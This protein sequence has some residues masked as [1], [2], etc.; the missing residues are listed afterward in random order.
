MQ[1][2]VVPEPGEDVVARGA[3]LGMM[4]GRVRLH[5]G[6]TTSSPI[7]CPPLL[8]R[9]IDPGSGVARTMGQAPDEGETTGSVQGG[10]LV[11]GLTLQALRA[12]GA[13]LIVLIFTVA[14]MVGMLPNALFLLMI[15]MAPA[16][17]LARLWVRSGSG[18]S[19]G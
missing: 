3:V 8:P 19:S 17:L 16:T 10:R 6:P 9:R 4:G 13:A 14:Y 11:W 2:G 7:P 1:T 18:W 5:L 15:F 12:L